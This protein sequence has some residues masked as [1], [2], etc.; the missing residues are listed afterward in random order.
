MK[1]TM[2]RRRSLEEGAAFCIQHCWLSE[3][4]PHGERL[5][6]Q[7]RGRGISRGAGARDAGVNVRAFGRD[8]VYTRSEPIEEA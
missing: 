4:G 8:R 2:A 7:D 1:R 6:P 5:E 3:A